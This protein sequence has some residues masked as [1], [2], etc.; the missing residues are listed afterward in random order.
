MKF[1]KWKIFFITGLVCLVPIIAGVLLW[2]RLPEEIAIHFNIY[3]EPD[4]FASKGFTVFGLPLLMVIFQ[5]V[6]CATNDFQESIHGKNEKITAVT[7]WIIPVVTVVLQ[8][9]TFGYALKLNVDIRIVA[10]LLVGAV[11]IVT[12]M[13]LPKLGYVK[14]MNVSP[15]KAKK[16]NRFMGR[17]TV[18]MGILFIISTFL[19]PLYTVFCLGIL[20]P[21][22][23]IA[24]IYSIRE[25]KRK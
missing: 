9:V 3:N 25:G 16:I 21:F 18:I 10:A 4:N 13:C 8:A 19:P 15:E 23:I 7:K 24:V 20:I 22:V 14:N 12:G 5:F 1:I 6:C 17:G 11:F 2:D